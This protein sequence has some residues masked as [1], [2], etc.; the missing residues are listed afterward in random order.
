MLD[1][2]AKIKVR[3]SKPGSEQGATA[4][5]GELEALVGP[6]PAMQGI[7]APNS[8]NGIS[9]WLDKLAAAIEGSDGAPSPDALRAFASV[10]ASLD[11]L[12]P[13]WHSFTVAAEAGST[14]AQ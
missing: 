3:L 12:E 8:L 7:N 11:A 6:A 4:L 13:R 10:S 9:A 1:E 2:A 5:N 14:A